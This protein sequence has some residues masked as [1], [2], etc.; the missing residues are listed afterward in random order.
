VSAVTFRPAIRA[1]DEEVSLIIGLAGGT[2]SGK[3]FSALRLATGIAAARP[4]AFIDTENGRARFYCDRFKFDHA[5]LTAPF[6]PERYTEAFLVAQS[7]GYPVCVI[8]SMSHMWAGEGGILEQHDRELDR[9][10]GQDWGKR[11]ACNMAAWIRPK[12]AHKVMVAKMLQ[13]RMHLILCFRAEEKVEMVKD[14][15]GKTKIVAKRSL[16]GLDGWMPICEKS[17]PFELTT[18]LLLTADAPGLPKPINLKEPHRGFLP[19]DAPISEDAGEQFARWARGAP[20]GEDPTLQSLKDAAL[21][22]VAA[23]GKRWED[24]G[25]AGRKRYA[26]YKDA[27]KAAAELVD[28]ETTA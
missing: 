1:P 25:M 14:E 3:T 17:L 18:S 24:I 13:L 2:G 12:M 6:T 15:K 27:L 5:E 7:A 10:A 20:E 26:Q 16:T 28:K 9:M 21:E 4:I 19:L 8:D 23:L 11:E 22:G